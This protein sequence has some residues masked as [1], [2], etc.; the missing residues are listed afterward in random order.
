MEGSKSDIYTIQYCFIHAYSVNVLE[1][2]C[3]QQRGILNIS[4]TALRYLLSWKQYI[5]F[6]NVLETALIGVL[7]VLETMHGFLKCLGN[8]A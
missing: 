6:L 1:M 5:D 7:N 3:K 8:S 2:S 4:E